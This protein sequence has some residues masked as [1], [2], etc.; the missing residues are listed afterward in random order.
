MSQVCSH[1]AKSAN[2]QKTRTGIGWVGDDHSADLVESAMF[3][4]GSKRLVQFFKNTE[5][6]NFMLDVT[7]GSH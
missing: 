6:H 4:P 1:V 7:A 2:M 5:F 3:G